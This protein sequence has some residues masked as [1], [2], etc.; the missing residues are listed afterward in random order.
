M[1]FEFIEDNFIYFVLYK[2]KALTM[3]VPHI[4]GV[5]PCGLV[6]LNESKMY[7]RVMKNTYRLKLIMK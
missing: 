6:M 4:T 7:K 3:L 5:P 1:E 2:N